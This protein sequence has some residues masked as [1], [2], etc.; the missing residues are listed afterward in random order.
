M[1]VILISKI[2]SASLP[3]SIEISVDKVFDSDALVASVQSVCSI[4]Q[5]QPEVLIVVPGV[6][7]NVSTT[8][9]DKLME[10]ISLDQTILI[11]VPLPIS[12]GPMDVPH[13]VA[14]HE[15]VRVHPFNVEL[16]VPVTA[17]PPNHLLKPVVYPV[18]LFLPVRRPVLSLSA[19]ASPLDG[20]VVDTGVKVS[21]LSHLFLH[22]F[23]LPLFLFL[24]LFLGLGGLSIGFSL[25]SSCF[26]LTL[27]L[28]FLSGFLLS[29]LFGFF[30]LY[31]SFF[32]FPSLLS[33][34]LL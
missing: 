25:L 4:K 29:L 19:I 14:M 15:L 17:C 24:C 33:F 20:I 1:R 22:G 27:L 6:E 10:A 34:L 12:P 8:V 11:A 2:E 28:S 18:L 9:Q 30:C 13:V 7:S 16:S 21:V 3:L 31:T 23:E 26:S 5:T 32:S